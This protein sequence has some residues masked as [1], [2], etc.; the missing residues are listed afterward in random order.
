M[1]VSVSTVR[2]LEDDGA[3]TPTRSGDQDMRLHDPAQVRAL[4]AA[5]QQAG[6]GAADRAPTRPDA[7]GQDAIPYDEVF[8]LF[9]SGVDPV[10]IVMETG[11]P[12][13]QVGAALDAY[14]DLRNNEMVG[15]PALERLAAV[16][17]ELA[18]VAHML[19]QLNA[20]LYAR[21]HCPCCDAWVAPRVTVQYPCCGARVGVP[22]L[23]PVDE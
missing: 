8:R 22:S 16:E 21:C 3:L 6:R 23:H 11:I 12:P 4:H 10:G 18:S 15:M 19:A 17:A 2:R 9:E 5:R 13:A 20:Q 1:G 14:Y 7:C